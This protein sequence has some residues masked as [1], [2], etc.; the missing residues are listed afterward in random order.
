[1]LF[2]R[3]RG[4]VI[5]RSPRASA[6]LASA[7]R[8]TNSRVLVAVAGAQDLAKTP[9]SSQPQQVQQEQERMKEDEDTEDEEK[10]EAQAVKSDLNAAAENAKAASAVKD[11]PQMPRWS[12]G[13]DDG[14]DDDEEKEHQEQVEPPQSDISKDKEDNGG[15]T[16]SSRSSSGMQP[17]ESEGPELSEL[18]EVVTRVLEQ[19]GAAINEAGGEGGAASL[20]AAF[21]DPAQAAALGEK[22]S[23]ALASQTKEGQ[24]L[25]HVSVQ[26]GVKWKEIKGGLSHIHLLLR[27]M[28][29]EF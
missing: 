20:H 27:A 26:V 28:N 10:E 21:K 1:V 19:L 8:R 11:A 23:S 7:T 18:P 2:L 12:D 22:L 13:L 16:D 17:P 4:D 14:D 5:M 15:D 9:V 29:V 24:S 3:S 25:K 6:A